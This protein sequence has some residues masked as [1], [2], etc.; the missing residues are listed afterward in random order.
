MFNPAK[1][2]QWENSIN[3]NEIK[4]LLV[5]PQHFLKP[6]I[7]SNSRVS[8]S[9]CSQCEGEIL[10]VEPFKLDFTNQFS[11]GL[12]KNTGK[13]PE[14]A[15]FTNWRRENLKFLLERHIH[16]DDLGLDIGA[17][18]QKLRPYLSLNRVI[19]LDFTNYEGI[20]IVCDLSQKI[21][22]ASYAFD[23]VIMTN[24]LEH[25]FDDSVLKEAHRL[26][27]SGS[28][29]YITV[30]FLLEVHQEPYDYH[31]Y[32]YLYLEK[33]LEDTGFKIEYFSGS[34]DIR[35]FETQAWH[36][37]KHYMHKGDRLNIVPRLLWRVQKI[38]LFLLNNLIG[39]RYRR[40]YTLGY[41]ISAKKI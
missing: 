8:C 1:G 11:S 26:L 41:M 18:D 39:G 6:L 9:Q 12:I 3:L 10:R 24:L 37:F 21:P 20:N 32:T 34:T 35:T 22:L 31:R 17:G 14:I 19:T 28:H 7:V 36:Y 5:C 2:I 29:L 25:L 15:N 23:Y 40:G 4:S 30:P 38:V 16:A 13:K 27:K 33:K